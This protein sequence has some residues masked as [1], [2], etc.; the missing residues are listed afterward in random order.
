MPV[1]AAASLGR[2]L[3]AA[4]GDGGGTAQRGVRGGWL[5][6][7]VGGDR[8]RCDSWGWGAWDP[9]RRGILME[10]LEEVRRVLFSLLCPS[11]RILPQLPLSILIPVVILT[12]RPHGI[13]RLRHVRFR[14][15]YWFGYGLRLGLWQL[16]LLFLPLICFVG[17]EHILLVKDGMGELGLDYGGAE[18]GFDSVGDYWEFEDLVAGGSFG[19]ADGQT[20][21]N[22]LLQTTTIPTTHWWISPPNNLHRQL[23]YTPPLKRR[24]LHTQL[25]QHD[26]HTPHIR[27][28]T[29]EI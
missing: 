20:H 29:I 23:L 8:R 16:A 22:Q 18:A 19:G 7:A 26:T 12:I 28:V 1:R 10:L 11:L 27:R 13:N 5:V 24:L 17:I 9:V 14:R 3:R 21:S 4:D 2:Y 25:I 6:A 15:L